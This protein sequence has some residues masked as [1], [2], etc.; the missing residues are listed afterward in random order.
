VHEYPQQTERYVRP[1]LRALNQE[2]VFAPDPMIAWQVFGELSQPD[3][4]MSRRVRDILPR[5][6]SPDFRVRDAALRELQKLGR[7]GAGVLVHMDR[8]KLTPEQNARIDRALLPYGHLAPKE[9]SRLRSDAGFLLDCLYCDESAIR[10]AAV[11]R[12]RSMFRPDLAFDVDAPPPVRAAVIA[13]LRE[14]LKP[15]H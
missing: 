5:L 8:S 3:A 13:Q 4:A 9:I 14:Q 11:D 10:Q 7:D 15:V 1:L 2:S 6:D 12:L